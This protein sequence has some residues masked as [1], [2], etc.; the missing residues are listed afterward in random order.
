[1]IFDVDKYMYGY[2]QYFALAFA[3]MF[4]GKVCLW[5]DVDY[6][7]PDE[8]HSTRLCHAYVE[9]LDGLYVDAAGAFHNINVRESEF[10]YNEQ[11]IVKLSI[12]NAKKYLR[13]LGIPYGDTETKR[14][15]REF[16]RNNMLCLNVRLQDDRT[17]SF[18]LYCVSKNLDFV[19]LMHYNIQGFAP[20]ITKFSSTTFAQ[21]VVGQRGFLTNKG[22]YEDWYDRAGK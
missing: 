20:C 15:V 22:W 1:M 7:A 10:E 18:G 14:E 11:H 9:I 6:A 12:D 17:F 8:R 4:N 2:C 16:L 21:S 3:E 5:L 19:G 13:K